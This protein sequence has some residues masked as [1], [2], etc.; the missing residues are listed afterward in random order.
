MYTG[1]LGIIGKHISQHHWT[2]SQCIANIFCFP[3]PSSNSRKKK[4]YNSSKSR[5]KKKQ[6]KTIYPDCLLKQFPLIKESSMKLAYKSIQLLSKDKCLK[7]KY[8]KHSVVTKTADWSKEV[9]ALKKK[10]NRNSDWAMNGS[11]IHCQLAMLH[12]KANVRL[13]ALT[14]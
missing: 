5:K 9:T 13:K 3:K 2:G 4:K 1:F 7:W 6:N 14:M 12:W 11:T 10:K 8:L